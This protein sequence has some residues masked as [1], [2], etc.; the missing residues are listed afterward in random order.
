MAL[1]GGAVYHI[2]MITPSSPPT[3]FQTEL[4]SYLLYGALSMNFPDDGQCCITIVTVFVAPLSAL[5]NPITIPCPQQMACMY[6]RVTEST[7]FHSSIQELQSPEGFASVFQ[8]ERK[9]VD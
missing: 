4:Y 1:Q 8:E 2:P 5:H 6:Y 7:E 9:Q 3:G